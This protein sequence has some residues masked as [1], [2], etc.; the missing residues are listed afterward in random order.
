MR[1]E[2]VTD[3]DQI[4]D[5][6]EENSGAPSWFRARSIVPSRCFRLE[7]RWLSRFRVDRV[8]RQMGAGTRNR[9]S[10]HVIVRSSPRTTRKSPQRAAARL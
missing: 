5:A 7:T 10:S 8:G 3:T 6:V 9:L 4:A 1:H 2:P